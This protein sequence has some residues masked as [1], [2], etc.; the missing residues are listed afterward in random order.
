[1]CLFQRLTRRNWSC[2][3]PLMEDS[4]ASCIPYLAT[5]WW[6][7]V[8]L[9]MPWP[10]CLW[11]KNVG[12]VLLGQSVMSCQRDNFA[13]AAVSDLLT[14]RMCSAVACWHHMC[15]QHCDTDHCQSKLALCKPWAND[16]HSWNTICQLFWT[17]GWERGGKSSVGHCTCIYCRP[18]RMCTLNTGHLLILINLTD[19]LHSIFEENVSHTILKN[20]HGSHMTTHWIMK[21]MNWVPV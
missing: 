10:L 8:S 3:W 20:P 21:W 6:L 15:K 14:Q 4:Q 18:C 1:M 5:S 13:H 19:I 17:V 16:R 9:M 12:C 7:M 2:T 11:R